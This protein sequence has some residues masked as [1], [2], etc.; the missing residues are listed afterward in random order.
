M[1][2]IKVRICP[3]C[4]ARLE[5]ITVDW[6]IHQQRLNGHSV[7]TIGTSINASPRIANA[8]DAQI[9]SNIAAYSFAYD[10]EVSLGMFGEMF[11]QCPEKRSV[12][13]ICRLTNS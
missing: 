1:A 13:D 9:A 12:S 3:I 6:V 8:V 2:T 4:G 5:N 7:A 11:V 10:A